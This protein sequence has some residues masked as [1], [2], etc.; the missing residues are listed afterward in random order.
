M[1]SGTSK[2]TSRNLSGEGWSYDPASNTLTLDNFNYKGEGHRDRDE[3]NGAIYSAGS[4]GLTL[5]LKGTS[6]VEEAGENYVWL[7][8]GVY[9]KGKLTVTGDGTIN[10]TSSGGC[11]NIGIYTKGDIVIDGGTVNA[12]A[13][14][15]TEYDYNSSGI[16]SNGSIT[17]NGGTV[18]G[19]GGAAPDAYSGGIFA[20]YD[21]A[22]NGGSVTGTGG[23]AGY[24]SWGLFSYYGNISINE[25]SGEKPT[26]V[27]AAGNSRAI[28]SISVKS[29]ISGMGWNDAS[30]EGDGTFIPVNTEGTQYDYRKIVFPHVHSFTAQTVDDKYLAAAATCTAPASYYKICSI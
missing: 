27:V 19:T 21:L 9:T 17:I 3:N 2:N 6:T 29:S 24:E 5:Y 4:D 1:S 20:Y 8:M 30:G 22:I 25:V 10:A 12:V 7:A 28:E 15:V 18:K 11:H 14:D 23:S 13:G 26:S 16:Y